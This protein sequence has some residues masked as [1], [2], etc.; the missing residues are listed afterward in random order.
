MASLALAL[1]VV[2]LV[3]VVLCGVHLH[4]RRGHGADGRTR[5]LRLLSPV[6]L[7]T[8]ALPLIPLL[9]YDASALLWGLWGAGYLTAALVHAAAG[10]ARGSVGPPAPTP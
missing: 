3:A 1:V 9:A 8:S 5:S 7:A 2:Q 4:R 6:L 10:S